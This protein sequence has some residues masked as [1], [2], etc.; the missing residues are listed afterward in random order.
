MST[1]RVTGLESAGFDPCRGGGHVHAHLVRAFL[2]AL[3]AGVLPGYFW[4]RFLCPA[5]GLGERL[6]YSTVLSMASVPPA[7]LLLARIGGRGVTLWVAVASVVI[8]FGAGAVAF[9][10]RGPAPALPGPV[11]RPPVIRD[12]RALALIVVAFG[13]ALASML[14]M[15][16]PG[17]LLIVIIVVLVLAAA[18]V[19]RPA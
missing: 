11:L 1:L 16:R 14:R 6:A 8:V 19:A 4:A 18:L 13:L 15:P 12:G 3:A 5:S 2:G 9:A 10:A 7:A 17:W